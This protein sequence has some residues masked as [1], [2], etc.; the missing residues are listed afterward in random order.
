[1]HSVDEQV[2]RRVCV[3]CG[4]SPGVEPAYR[5]EAV[6]LGRLLGEAGLGLVY[7][8]AQ[9]GLMGA[10]ADAALAH[11]SEVIGVIP[12]SLAGIEVAHQNL[13]QLV[14]VETMHERKALMAQEADAFVALPGGYGTLDEFFEILTWAQLGIH[15]KPCVLLNTGGYYDQLLSFL[16]V[17]VNQGFLK[18]GNYA[19]IQVVESAGDAL[20]CMQTLWQSLPVSHVAPAEPAP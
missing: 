5:A 19:L 12:R 11:G 20:K 4:S 13:S 7:G 1:M 3:F 6:T 14:L 17:A 15:A 10:L 16:K 18:P 2:Q 9:V 8:G